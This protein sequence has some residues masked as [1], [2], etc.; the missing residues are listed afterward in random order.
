MPVTVSG[1]HVLFLVLYNNSA[2]KLW[3]LCHPGFCGGFFLC[4]F[5]EA[6]LLLCMIWDEGWPQDK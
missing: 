5:R 6:K 3:P 1:F 4:T 2:R